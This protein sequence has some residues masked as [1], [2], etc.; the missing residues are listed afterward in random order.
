ML[1]RLGTASETSFGPSLRLISWNI[2]KARR[3]GWLTDLTTIST[4]ADLVLLQEAVL[5]GGVAQPFH[6]ASGRS[7][8]HTSELQSH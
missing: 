7:E 8:E 2:Y 1:R 6:I 5:H 4:G 3:R